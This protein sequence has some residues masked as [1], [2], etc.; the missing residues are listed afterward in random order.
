MTRYRAFG[1]TIASAI[2]LLGV[3]PDAASPDITMASAPVP[4]PSVDWFEIWPAERAAPR[5]RG[6]R[7]PGGYV[8][9]YDGSSAF[10]VSSAGD[11]IIV[12]PA[13][14][15]PGMLRHR[16]LDQVL[17]LA[18][19]LRCAVLHASV[20]SA[21]GLGHAF[22]GPAGA[23]KSSLARAWAD[24]GSTVIA[25][26]AAVVR[27]EG[28]TFIVVP[29]YPG[30]RVPRADGR[31]ERITSD[32][33]FDTRPAPLAAI[34]A[35]DTGAADRVSATPMTPRDAAI[36]VLGQLFRLEQQD[37]ARLRQELHVASALVG[38]VPVFHL[39]FPRD[40]NPR[41]VVTEVM[42]HARRSMAA[43]P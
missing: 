20:V 13:D 27:R 3:P 36:V 19:S 32:V 5:V 6:A 17:P 39:A 16:L 15:D 21:G 38:S 37:R 30:V 25:D 42:R 33:A 28:E 43:H 29:S 26:D 31:K 41:A 8:V 22:I 4:L 23:G 34:Y 12:D 14:C 2:E 24:S 7:V 9:K 40:G 11:A 10:H 35:V 18:L 1:L